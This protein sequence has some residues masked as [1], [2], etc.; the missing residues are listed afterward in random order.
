LRRRVEEL[1]AQLAFQDELQQRLDEVVT[2]QD[3]ELLELKKL[4][5]ELARRMAE[6]RDSGAAAA[7][8][9]DEVPPHY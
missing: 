5:R 7:A 3:R 8:T 1:E 9:A 4:L 6:L 2:R